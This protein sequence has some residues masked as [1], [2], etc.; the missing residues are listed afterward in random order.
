VRDYGLLD[1]KATGAPPR[2]AGEAP[3]ACPGCGCPRVF[4]IE[5]E[6]EAPSML[7]VPKGS[8]A[9][10]AYAGCAACPWASPAVITAK[11]GGKA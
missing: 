9:V 11:P 8:R 10:A 6:V 1:T 5:A 2:I 7:R 4:L 3:G